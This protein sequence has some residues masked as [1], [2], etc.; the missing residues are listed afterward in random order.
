MIKRY[1]R[2]GAGKI[3]DRLRRR[4][5]EVKSEELIK[6]YFFINPGTE[7]EVLIAKDDIDEERRE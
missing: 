4:Y 6:N 3:Y 1:V 5:I 7:D 2:E